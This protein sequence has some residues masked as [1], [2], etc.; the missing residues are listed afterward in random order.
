MST[1]QSGS[2]TAA[3]GKSASYWRRYTAGVEPKGLRSLVDRDAP[4]VYS[5][6][7]RDRERP[8][9][10]RGTARNFFVD[11]RLLF[12]SISEKLPP[13]RAIVSM[14][15]HLNFKT[16][17][18]TE[19][20]KGEYLADFLTDHADLRHRRAIEDH[21]THRARIHDVEKLLLGVGRE[22]ESRGH[23]DGGVRVVRQ[24]FGRR[25]RPCCDL[26]RACPRVRRWRCS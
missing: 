17:P 26:F 14:G 7:M 5:V 6:L 19:Y 16:N 21:D 22:G 1:K 11:A 15:V 2:G 23:R 13:A 24:A 12:E 10:L 8:K 25:R 3:R 4:R 18:K 20:P 9:Q